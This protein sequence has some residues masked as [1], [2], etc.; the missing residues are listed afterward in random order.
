V[1]RHDFEKEMVCTF[2]R[3]SPPRGRCSGTMTRAGIHLP[4][5]IGTASHHFVTAVHAINSAIPIARNTNTI[6]R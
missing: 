1:P 3:T 6:G 4:P 5:T 2:T